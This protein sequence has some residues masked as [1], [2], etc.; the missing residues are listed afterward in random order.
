MPLKQ[1]LLCV[2]LFA[3]PVLAETT[4]AHS[5]VQLKSQLQ[6]V[7]AD[8]KTDWAHWHL[9]NQWQAKLTPADLQKWVTQAAQKTVDQELKLDFLR[10]N[11][12]SRSYSLGLT[13]Q[14]GWAW[15]QLEL[16]LSLPR[17]D[18]LELR[19]H[20]NWIPTAWLNVLLARQLQSRL[21]KLFMGAP[22]LAIRF[23]G[24]V[25]QV[26]WLEQPANLAL[27]QQAQVELLAASLNLALDTQGAVGI[28]VN[29]PQLPLEQALLVLD[30]DLSGQSLSQLTGDFALQAQLDL[31]QL[32]L[33]Q[34]PA[35]TRTL[36]DR[37]QGGTVQLQLQGQISPALKAPFPTVS[38]HLQVQMSNA[39]IEGER[40]PKIESL[41]I[42]WRWQDQDFQIWPAYT[43][44]SMTPPAFSANLLD[45]FVDGPDY[46]EEMQAAI[47]QARE[48]V[49]Q[50][51]FVFYDGEST[52]QLVRLYLTKALGLTRHANGQW[53]ADPYAPAGIRVFLL[54]NHGLNRKGSKKVQAMFDRESRRLFADLA[55]ANA[56]PESISTYKQRLAQHVQVAPLTRGAF[57]TDHRKLLV[58]DGEIA[59]TGGLN[60]GDHYLQADA[61]HDLMVRVKG[62][63]VPSLHQAF[64]DNFVELRP[65]QSW[66][67]NLKS[68][69]SLTLPVQTPAS[70]VAALLTDDHLT[71]IEPAILQ[72]IQSAQTRIRL[73][74][75]YLYYEPIQ[76]ALVRA[77]ERGVKLELIVSERNDESIYELLNLDA[78]RQLMLASQQPGQVQVRLFQSRG[79]EHDFMSH[80]KYLT[81][82]GQVAIVGS[83]NLIP[84]SL[85]S[86]FV[87]KGQAILF[88]EELSLLIHDPNFVR[89]LDQK[90][91]EKDWQSRSRSV[92]LKEVERLLAER[93]GFLQL[94]LAKLQGLLT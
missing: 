7:S 82:D 16:E 75:A 12:R 31:N 67:W 4:E 39:L 21:G 33:D 73:E 84:R 65:E 53:L 58:I 90:L 50:E 23:E 25:L 17:P 24:Q 87:A 64:I 18:R 93:G 60:L 80:T 51:I 40:I 47:A 6:P 35:G 36:A 74:Q 62:P 91:F 79:G 43:A 48:S 32:E 42:H 37:V 45:L 56:L 69:Q 8:Q 85:R 38:G 41:P 86:P 1:I 13:L 57:K 26:Q 30:A 54:H 44:L 11:P 3:S 20:H 68:P 59:Y 92:D 9:S 88:N 63:L 71:E 49:D 2:L 19:F 27:G 55:Q 94:L 77:L 89:L 29:S 22:P 28:Q 52:S 5:Q 70:Q 72:A 46:F 78:I 34:I 81:V 66:V 14:Q 83:A 15:D 10:F 61:F 76:Q